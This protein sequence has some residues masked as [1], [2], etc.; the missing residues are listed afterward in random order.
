MFRILTEIFA[1]GCPAGCSQGL[2]GRYICLGDTFIEN[3]RTY[4]PVEQ[5]LMVVLY[6]NIVA[7]NV[8]LQVSELDS[9]SMRESCMVQQLTFSGQSH[10]WSHVNMPISNGTIGNRIHSLVVD[11]ASVAII[12]RGR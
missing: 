9:S 3:I 4:N 11:R 10:R 8:H 12:L 1:P 2:C 7:G 6:L 5:F